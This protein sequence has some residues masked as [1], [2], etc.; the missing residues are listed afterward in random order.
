MINY[1]SRLL[2]L[3]LLAAIPFTVNA[4]D[5]IPVVIFDQG[6]GQRFLIEGQGELQ[7]SGLA[8]IIGKE[9]TSVIATTKPLTAE[10]ISSA[11]AL[12]ISGAFAPY[13]QEELEAIKNFVEQGGHLAVMLH[14]GQPVSDLLHLFS[15]DISNMVLHEQQ[16]IIDGKDIN[17]KVTDLPG[18]NIFAGVQSFS[19]Y[20]AW[21]LNPGEK[22]QT[23]ASSSEKSWVDLNG[24]KKLSPEDVVAK[25]SVVVGGDFGKGSVLFFGDDAVFQ[26]RYL[27]DNNRVVA[28]NLAKW[29]KQ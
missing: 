25:F 14:I 16:D 3:L 20:G 13:K 7:L 9:G 19:L 28:A 2:L 5:K 26:N 21:A 4:E 15:V 24:D 11:K 29:L 1:I 10:T 6:H 22:V 17:F 27:V 18:S 12:V 23:L 8:G